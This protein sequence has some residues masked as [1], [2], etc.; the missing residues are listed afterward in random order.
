[1]VDHAANKGPRGEQVGCSA[2]VMDAPAFSRRFR[3]EIT[4]TFTRSHMR[5]GDM[6]SPRL[7]LDLAPMN[8]PAQPADTVIDPR[9]F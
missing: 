1:M 3:P 6:R 5:G 2:F 7:M 9:A 8:D 4:L